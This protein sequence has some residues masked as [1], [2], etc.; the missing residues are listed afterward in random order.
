MASYK[1]KFGTIYAYVPRIVFSKWE[2]LN[3]AFLK[4]NIYDAARMKVTNIY[5]RI[6]P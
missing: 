2:W 5:K 1:L 4:K 3:L 6:K